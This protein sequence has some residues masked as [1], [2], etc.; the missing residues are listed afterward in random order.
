MALQ[1]LELDLTNPLTIEID[2]HP[3]YFFEDGSHFP[4]IMGGNGADDDE[5]DEEDEE[6]EDEEDDDDDEGQQT[7]AMS[8]EEASRVRAALKK[9]NR[10]AKKY[11]QEARK[12][13]K[14]NETETERKIREAKEEAA[15]AAEAKFKKIA[16]RAEAKAQ[17]AQAG[18]NGKADRFLKMIDLEDVEVDDDG[19]IDGLDDQIEAIKAEFPEVFGD[20]DDEGNNKRKRKKVSRIDSGNK[21]SKSGG[22]KSTA[23]KIAAQV[24]RG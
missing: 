13:K 11:R 22:K 8:A 9:A 24:L 14:T 1:D 5:E 4:A 6:D 18:L 17:F 15:G 10:E 20:E 19:E 21:E 7:G 16:V 3:W 2:G 23:E 12:L